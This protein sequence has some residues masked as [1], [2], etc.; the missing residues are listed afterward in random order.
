MVTRRMVVAA[1][2]AA[3]LLAGCSATGGETSGNGAL[4][5]RT[6][7][8][9]SAT[10]AAAGGPAGAAQSGASSP[11]GLEGAGGAAGSTPGGAAASASAGPSASS[12]P[13][14]ASSAQQAPAAT[15]TMA[16]LQIGYYGT[17]ATNGNAFG[18]NG[19]VLGD[20]TT[21]GNA[22]AN[23]VNGHGGLGGHPMKLVV[24]TTPLV[25]STPQDQVDQSACAKF[26]QDNH[27][28]AALSIT[29]TTATMYKCLAD[30]N[31]LYI[32]NTVYQPDQAY[33]MAHGNM[34]YSTAP[35]QDRMATAEADALWRAGYFGDPAEKTAIVTSD[36]PWFQSGVSAFEQE[37][38]KHGGHVAEVVTTCHTPCPSSQQS[39]QAQ[40]DVIKLRT[41]GV[42]HVV[43]MTLESASVFLQAAQAAAYTPRYGVDSD[44]VPYDL[45]T[46]EPASVFAGGAVGAG[47]APS[48]D[49]PR[50]QNPPLDSQT[51][52]CEQIMQ[53]A[54]VNESDF[55]VEIQTWMTCDTF[56]LLK[57][58]L[59][60]AGGKADYSTMESAIEGIGA[61]FVPA[62][63]FVD[64]FGPARHDGAQVYRMLVYS[65]GCQCF[66]YASTV[67]YPIPP[68]PGQS[69]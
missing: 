27:V 17:E 18:V 65:S 6:S 23:W 37:A 50:S 33:Y 51:Q 13:A 38:A 53:Q 32:A 44:D 19:Q 11:A 69:Q 9:G 26:T 2:M 39:S 1:L 22:M 7:S 36:Y 40:N 60:R 43:L 20:P 61:S 56:F 3:S 8:A 28:F 14:G 10:S 42:N 25:S 29:L 63:G 12:G 15:G 52:L 59:D 30:H 41:D 21:I 16:P 46:T 34:L 54:G 58:A 68:L 31:V 67:N 62:N 24:A 45:G 47:Y 66:H 48:L 4:N 49:V 57:A 35:T 55:S 64:W 5:L